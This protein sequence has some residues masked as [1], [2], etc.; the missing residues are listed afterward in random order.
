MR[1]WR[2]FLKYRFQELASISINSQD[3]TNKY[4]DAALENCQNLAP[5]LELL[6][7]IASQEMT[8]KYLASK[9]IQQEAGGFQALKEKL[10]QQVLDILLKFKLNSFYIKIARSELQP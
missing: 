7:G 2:R 8:K 1:F 5:M 6:H 9:V 4:K 10:L 3:F